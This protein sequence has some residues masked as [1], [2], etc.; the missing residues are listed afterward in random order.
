MKLRWSKTSWLL[1]RLAFL[2]SFEYIYFY[3][4]E[5]KLFANL[6]FDIKN[7]F[8]LSKHNSWYQ[9][10]IQFGTID[11]ELKQKQKNLSCPFQYTFN[12]KK[13]Q[14]RERGWWNDYSITFMI[15]H[16]YG[17]G[18][19]GLVVFMKFSF[20]RQLLYKMIFTKSTHA[21]FVQT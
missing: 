11:Q 18:L 21:I 6:E 3:M 20:Q 17:L 5:L 13:P 15:Y 2:I 1:H 8:W 16:F 10:L 4:R 7:I 9:L 12:L 14:V 19:R